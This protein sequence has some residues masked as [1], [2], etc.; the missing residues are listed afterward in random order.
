MIRTLA[1][2]MNV[3][4]TP[5]AY[6]LFALSLIVYRNAVDDKRRDR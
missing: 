2:T 1:S 6:S 3:S 5:H 4:H